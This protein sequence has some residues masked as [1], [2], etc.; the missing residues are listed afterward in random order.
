[1][2]AVVLLFTAFSSFAY[3]STSYNY[4][5]GLCGFEHC[6]SRVYA[7]ENVKAG[8]NSEFFSIVPVSWDKDPYSIYGKTVTFTSS[9]TAVAKVARDASEPNSCEVTYIKK[10]KAT[11]TAKYKG[12]VI[13]KLNVT[14]KNG[15]KVTKS[16]LDVKFKSYYE[17]PG[18]DFSP[19][20]TVKLSGNVLKNTIDYQTWTSKT[21][22]T[23]N[24]NLIPMGLYYGDNVTYKVK[25]VPKRTAITEVTAASKAFTVKWK[26]QAKQ[27]TG[28][29]IRYSLNS[30]MSG[31]KTVTV[32]STST[33][34]KK[35]TGLKAKKKYYVQVRTYKVVSGKNYYSPWGKAKSVTT[36]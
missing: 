24:A 8:M 22:G 16:K 5:F 33:L 36:K 34:S 17:T 28:Y 19:E 11:I 20:C 4:T 30:D 18:W 21:V 15:I 27:T 10:G 12:K 14:I 29:Q 35:I 23:R 1:M 25:V 2:L 7:I 26:K 6:S 13:A 9:N 3:G 31:A 32:A